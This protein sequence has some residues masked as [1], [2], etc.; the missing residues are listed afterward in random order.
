MLKIRTYCIALIALML[1]GYSSLHAQSDS[2]I[3]VYAHAGMYSL[4]SKDP[5]GASSFGV[6]PEG[7]LGFAYQ[8]QYRHFVFSTGLGMTVGSASFHSP[9]SMV[10]LPN[11]IDK[12]QYV[13]TYRYQFSKRHDRYTTIGLQIPIM[14]GFSVNNLILMAGCKL[15][16]YGLCSTNVKSNVETWGEYPQF[17]DPFTGMPEHQFYSATSV[18]RR[19]AYRLKPE[20]ALSLEAAWVIT[21]RY[22]LAVYADYGINNI[23]SDGIGNL[24]SVPSVFS[25]ETSMLE[26]VQFTHW[27]GSDRMNGG[28]LHSLTAG[29]R[30]TV[31]FPLSKK[32]PCRCME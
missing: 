9:D 2:K 14:A 32:Y 20:I 1:A 23:G 18:T 24:I 29:V 12:D 27:L 3:G 25:E 16:W 21:P 8:L 13:F 19:G 17:V 7:G 10:S 22:Q 6:G 15:K 31:F 11:S 28:Q 4:L 26:D 30:F 5:T